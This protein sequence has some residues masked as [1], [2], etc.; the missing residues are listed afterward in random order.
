MRRVNL[1]PQS[2]QVVNGYPCLLLGESIS[3]TQRSHIALS[4]GMDAPV[5]IPSDGIME[6]P[7][8]PSYGMSSFSMESILAR[9]G[10]LETRSSRR[11]SPLS[12][13]ITTREP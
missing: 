12:V 2:V 1:G 3:S 9:G 6:N 10:R 13:S 11:S 7:L 5:P 4:A 8:G